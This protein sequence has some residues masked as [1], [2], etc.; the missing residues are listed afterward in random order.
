MT[1]IFK[2]FI[3]RLSIYYY[4]LE[5]PVKQR[6]FKHSGFIMMRL[7]LV[8]L[9]AFLF[10]FNASAQYYRLEKATTEII[11]HDS[12]NEYFKTF[13]LSSNTKFWI[14]YDKNKKPV[15]KSLFSG[16]ATSLDAY[17]SGSGLS[18]YK[19][20][21]VNVPCKN[22]APGTLFYLDDNLLEV[23][24]K[25]KVGIYTIKQVNTR[26]ISAKMSAN[27]K[28]DFT[29]GSFFRI[30]TL[31][32]L[33]HGNISSSLSGGEETV[34][35]TIF[36]NGRTISIKSSDDALWLEAKSGMKVIHYKMRN[37]DVYELVF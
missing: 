33:A 29:M 2:Y 23:V 17:K 6:L 16:Y 25:K 20:S 19:P 28:G 15:E 32:P 10:N 35:N 14:F 8:I 24:E 3:L 4:T 37:I 22:Y 1:K 5:Y 34:V 31:E 36:T 13:Y 18:S 12:G 9:M 30:F 11:K 21:N 26:T 7:F 27:L